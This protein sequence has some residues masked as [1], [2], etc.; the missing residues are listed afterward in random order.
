[1]RSKCRARGLLSRALP[2]SRP[3][4][5]ERAA[6]MA[7]AVTPREASS[8]ASSHRL[9]AL[10]R[11]WRISSRAAQ[12]PSARC[13]PC[14]VHA[15]A[16]QAL[17][18]TAHRQGPVAEAPSSNAGRLFHDVASHLLLAVSA[19][20]TIL[21][22]ARTPEPAPTVGRAAPTRI[23]SLMQ[24]LSR[25]LKCHACLCAGCAHKRREPQTHG[26]QLVSHDDA[27]LTP[28]SAC[29]G[30]RAAVSRAKRGRKSCG[31][32]AGASARRARSRRA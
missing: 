9:Q 27:T 14:S 8:S 24:G 15:R 13:A 6:S 2:V 10:R 32:R 1:M 19:P 5:R 30:R 16:I 23:H 26:K 31:P 17:A 3:P 21:G 28:T 29:R 22:G 25:A 7:A 20:H 12:G 11:A 18:A 4:G